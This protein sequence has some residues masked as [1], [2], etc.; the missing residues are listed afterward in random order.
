MPP[1]RFDGLP[2]RTVCG[3]RVPVASGFASRLLGLAGLSHAAAGP[4]L[5]IM[6]FPL[7]LVFLDGA[8]RPLSVRRGLAPGRFARQRGAAAVLEL[9]A[10]QGGEFSPPAT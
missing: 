1:R 4:G 3:H 7:D 9:P 5:L 10:A 6:R 8:G 2:L